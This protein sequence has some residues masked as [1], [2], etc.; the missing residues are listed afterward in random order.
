L[1]RLFGGSRS[2]NPAKVLD[3]EG[4]Q[5]APSYNMSDFS[6]IAYVKGGW[7]MVIEYQL[8]VPSVVVLTIVSEGVE[9]FYYNLQTQILARHQEKLRIPDRFG[10]KA[11]VA[12]YSIRALSAAPGEVKPVYLRIFGM[13]AGPR[14]VGSLKLDNLIL[15]PTAINTSLKEKTHFSFHSHDDFTRG[16]AVFWQVA[17]APRPGP[18]SK[19][20]ADEEPLKGPIDRDTG[21]GGYW[22]GKAKGKTIKGQY[23]VQ[24]C[25]WVDGDHGGDWGYAESGQLISVQ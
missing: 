18:A 9:P 22:D 11:R 1:G 25:A 2:Q 16:K 15:D 8:E 24:I 6:I 3:K 21:Y 20:R 10:D 7:P 5:F 23:Q 13:G 4:P 14:A 17:R 12:Q 19:Q